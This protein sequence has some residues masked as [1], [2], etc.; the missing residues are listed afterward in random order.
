MTDV[1]VW[2]G[3]LP[4]GTLYLLL[5]VGA[6][7]ENIVPPIPADTFVAIGGLFAGA[8]HLSALG[9][10]LGTWSFNVAG[11]FFVYWM[12]RTRGIAFFE[13]GIGTH[14]LK[15]HQMRLLER[16]YG[17]WGSPALF[18]SRFLPGVRA[19]VPVFAGIAGHPWQRTLV[20]IGTASAIWYG[21]LVYLGL[22]A[23]ENLALLQRTLGQVNRS[24]SVVAGAVVLLIGVWWHRTRQPGRVE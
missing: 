5:A 19:V 9:I 14:V 22:R 16:F 15:A 12:S 20:A 23:G 17:R 6:G 10:F 7:L 13:G 8:G 21:G 24:L 2:I 18:L 3:S 11:A 4:D 1:V